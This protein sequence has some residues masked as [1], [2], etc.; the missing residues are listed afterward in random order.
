MLKELYRRIMPMSKYPSY[1]RKLGVK[2]GSDCEIYNSAYFGT[3]PYLISIG[4]H[5]RIDSHVLF[6]THDGGYWVLRDPHSGFGREFSDA[7]H[8]AGI[9]VDDNVHI[10]MN[11]VIMP[12]VHIGENSVVGVGAVVT[13]D[14]PPRSIVGGGT[15]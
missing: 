12:G 15:G 7:D 11:A 2:I 5:V 8:I 9:T 4:N 13:H 6:L 3:E 14:V 10:G 1:L